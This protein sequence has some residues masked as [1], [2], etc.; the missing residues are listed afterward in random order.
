MVL[1]DFYESDEPKLCLEKYASWDRLRYVGENIE[2][3]RQEMERFLTW[4]E[5]RQ[6]RAKEYARENMSLSFIDMLKIV[7]ACGFEYFKHST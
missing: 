3:G 1:K 7:F 6:A 5:E 4:F 2:E